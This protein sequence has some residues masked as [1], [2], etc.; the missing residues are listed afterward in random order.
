MPG[1][2]QLKWFGL[3]EHHYYMVF[4]LL[5]NSLSDFK[6]KH[7]TISLKIIIGIGFQLVKL[8]ESI[9]NKHL[10]HRDIKPDN[11]FFFLCYKKAQLHIIDFGFC[12]NFINKEG[13]HM[14]QTT[15]KTPLGTPN[16]ISLNVHDGIEPSRRD[17]LESIV[18]ILLYL[19]ESTLPW[20]ELST[21]YDEYKNVGLK[22]KQVK[23][24]VMESERVPLPLREIWAYCR[25]LRFDESPNYQTIYDIMK[26]N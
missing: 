22:I 16:F 13:M 23:A 7:P 25:N 9:H 4:T 14:K 20:N 15:D 21:Y 19:F 12:K 10:L 17:D 11:F 26:K 8:I 1:I 5:G 3:D 18:Y 24:K 2:P 6:I